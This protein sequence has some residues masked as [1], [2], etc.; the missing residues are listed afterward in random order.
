MKGNNELN[1]LIVVILLIHRNNKY[2][3]RFD[4]WKYSMFLESL[5]NSNIQIQPIIEEIEEEVIM[6]ENFI[7]YIAQT[8]RNK[9][10][11]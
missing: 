11:T 9:I 7:D 10:I 6:N 4:K 2:K 8:I 3:Y 5:S 1:K